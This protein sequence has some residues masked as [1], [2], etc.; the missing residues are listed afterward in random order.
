M[1]TICTILTNTPMNV[2]C[3]QR[4]WQYPKSM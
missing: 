4:N 2:Y 3:R 1:S